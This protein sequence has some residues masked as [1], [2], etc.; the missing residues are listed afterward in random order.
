MRLYDIILS[1]ITS[2][3]LIYVCKF[4]KCAYHMLS[5]ALLI[6]RLMVMRPPP[7]PPIFRISS[8]DGFK[9][10]W[11]AKAD[12]WIAEVAMTMCFSLRWVVLFRLSSEDV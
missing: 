2:D 12:C 3:Q 1:I 11:P 4:Q 9:A 7:R 6:V 8:F 5:G 10:V